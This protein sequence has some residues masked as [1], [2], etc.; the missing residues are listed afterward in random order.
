MYV[1]IICI[2]IM[3]DNTPPPLLLYTDRS[4]EGTSI[5]GQKYGGNVEK[6]QALGLG[7]ARSEFE[8]RVCIEESSADCGS[9]FGFFGGFS[10]KSL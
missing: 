10:K 5:Y 1:C 6:L 3:T 2:Y 4:T 9:S 7:A 8:S